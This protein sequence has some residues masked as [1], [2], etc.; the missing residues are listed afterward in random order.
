MICHSAPR[1]EIVEDSSS[2]MPS[3]RHHAEWLSLVE[4]SG[5]FLTMPVLEK[6]E[7]KGVGRVGSLFNKK[8]PDP[9]GINLRTKMARWSGALKGVRTLFSLGVGIADLSDV[10]AAGESSRVPF[11][12]SPERGRV[13][14][15]KLK[16]YWLT[17]Q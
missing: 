17:R 12:L 8:T 16:A 2:I 3:T 14:W 10:G 13:V 4:V 5:T 15:L 1:S 11:C 6:R 7:N 9:N